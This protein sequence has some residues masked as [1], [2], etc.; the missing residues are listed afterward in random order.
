[1]DAQP[2]Y[3]RFQPRGFRDWLL[4]HGDHVFALC[5]YII[6]TVLFTWP[7]AANFRTFV[8]GNAF[9]VFHE[10]W[11]LRLGSSSPTGPFFL[12]STSASYYPT[13][14]PLYFQVL[15]PFNTLNFAWLS[16]LFGEIVAFNLLYMFTFFFAGFTTYILVK[17][18]TK[19][20]YAAFLA[21]VAFAF[22][23]IHTGQGF[24]HLNIMSAEF[25]PL[26]TYFMIKMARERT[27][28]NSVYT[29]VAM[30]LN[31]MCD[32]H[33]FLLTAAVFVIFHIYTFF[34][35]R[36]LIVNRGYIQ[37]LIVMI[38][39]TSL[40]GFVV[41]FQT[42]YGLFFVPK[43]IGA[44]SS[45]TRFLSAKSADL[46]SF[47]IPSSAN[48]FLSRYVATLNV[49]IGRSTVLPNEAATAYVGY[50]VLGLSLL[51]LI[52]FWKRRDVY[53]WGLL[54]LLG[55]ILAL[56]PYVRI[57]GT[58][59]PIP[60]IW[61]YLYYL[62]PLLNSFRA[63]YRFDYL[64]ALGLAILAGYG[65]T[66]LF[67]QF[68][69]IKVPAFSK[70]VVKAFVITIL[71]TLVIVEFLPIPYAEFYAPTPQFYQV[72][73]NDHSN[74]SVIEVPIQNPVQSLYLYYQSAYSAPL[75]DGSIPRSPQ[76]P[77]M[78]IQTA[79]FIDQL[80]YYT[81]GKAPAS[82]IVNQT[83]PITTLAPYIMA[84]Y[85]VKYIIV[86]KDLFNSPTAYLAYVDQL[87][88]LLGQPIYQDSAIVAFRF[89]PP[90]PNT[91]IVQFLRQYNN[92]SLVS[93]L[94]GNWLR[95]GIFGPHVRA[96]SGFAGLNVFS[97]TDRMIQLQFKV[98][99]VGQDYP[100]QLLVNGQEQGTYMAFQGVYNVYSTA[101][102]HIN[103]GENQI[104][105][106]SPTG[107]NVPSP[108]TARNLASSSASL[109][110]CVTATFKWIAPIAAYTT[111]Q[112]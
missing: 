68:S 96:M 42:A 104:F 101:Y 24:D 105:F 41:Y 57:L 78:I 59:T 17:Y 72:L 102:F 93:L 9:D 71:C 79:P 97:A 100:L 87:T 108:A 69:R 48:P 37:R 88:P 67:D 52:F 10:L 95:F 14:A 6:L 65:V 92:I 16:K 60:G 21:G 20:N 56:G 53:F 76:Y 82:D 11:Y 46:V 33:M 84:Q 23:P 89:V 107:C 32:L 54:A 109:N 15:S 45:V 85:N 4:D 29:G 51:G 63:P 111:I 36:K 25:I 94:Y 83:Y 13:G 12:F 40:L 66:G 44:A 39:L 18:L 74:F 91:G 98:A 112:A 26:F 30:I 38:T 49:D 8:N 80:G 110:N 22:A 58:P 5:M 1:M 73:A 64:V 19:N 7:L 81:P 28:W 31:A 43:S 75:I 27:T 86:H 47:F 103:A 99:G 2:I 77:S 90:S 70:M 34:T 62:I 50:T 55:A 61:G 35:Q 3:Q 106:F